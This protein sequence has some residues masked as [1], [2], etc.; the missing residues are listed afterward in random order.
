MSHHFIHGILPLQGPWI[1]NLYLLIFWCPKIYFLELYIRISCVGIAT[2]TTRFE[3]YE[4]TLKH[5]NEI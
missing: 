4:F 3:L 5:E 1:E 2:Y